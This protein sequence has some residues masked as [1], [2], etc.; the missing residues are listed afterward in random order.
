MS[1][2]PPRIV[3]R[4]VLAPL[5][6]AVCLLLVA[7]APLGF[8]AAA[9]VDLFSDRRMPTLR[10]V[11]FAT[12]YALHDALGLAALGGL[13]LLSGAGLRLRSP[14]MQDAHYAVVRF[15]IGGVSRAA[16]RLFRLR[17]LIEDAPPPRPGPVLVFSRH[18]G[19]GNSL[20]LVGVLMLGYGRRPRIVMLEKLQ[21]EPFFD[22]IG[23][24]LPNRFIR[25]DPA[26]RERSL[27]EIAD[28]A[29][30]T[31]E[32]DAIVLF[33]EGR[34]FTPTLRQRAIA[35]LR[36]RGQEEEARRAERMERVL[37][38]RAGGVMAAVTAAPQADVVF[39]AHTVLEDVGSFRDLRR[40]VPLDR[41][42]LG[43][44][45]RIPAAE[46]PRE[47]EA[48]VP[49]LYDWWARIDA[50]IDARAEGH[51][52]EPPARDVQAL[53]LAPEQALE[54]PPEGQPSVEDPPPARPPAPA[55]GVLG[56]PQPRPGG[57][58]IP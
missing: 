51:E 32:R 55:E 16:R 39:V 23:N 7:A 37:P 54:H 5:G 12:A 56:T 25:H 2:L 9:A 1:R 21:L 38:P 53:E 17:I 43:R 3:R 31:G 28:L 47:A 36:R 20:M 35:S 19:P 45:W 14:S 29:A 48:L 33:P 30:G 4:L 18:A 10:I 27:R 11:A 8:L 6:F 52:W 22:T 57:R 44:Y 42:V 58:E 15:W 40:R 34:D 26:R 46:V 49:W 13:W 24:R 41:P 50:W